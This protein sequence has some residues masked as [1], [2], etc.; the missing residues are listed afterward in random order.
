LIIKQP[1]E[2]PEVMWTSL[3]AMLDITEQHNIPTPSMKSESLLPLHGLV[4]VIHADAS[5][6]VVISKVSYGSLWTLEIGAVGEDTPQ[7]W[8]AMTDQDEFPA[9]LVCATSTERQRFSLLETLLIACV[10]SRSPVP[11]PL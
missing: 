1:E 6:Y 5:R 2:L 11:F 8:R 9:S 3:I 7:W 10:S 4:Q